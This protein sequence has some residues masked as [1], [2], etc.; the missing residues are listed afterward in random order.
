MNHLI[1]SKLHFFSIS[2][3]QDV[4]LRC[5]MLQHFFS[6]NFWGNYLVIRLSNYKKS[7]T[8]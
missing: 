7:K 5:L 3:L 4:S 6:A 1:H 8:L 2:P